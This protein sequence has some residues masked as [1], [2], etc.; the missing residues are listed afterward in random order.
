MADPMD[1]YPQLVA[2]PGYGN[3]APPVSASLSGNVAQS[4]GGA[5]AVGG[6][7]WAL[8]ALAVLFGLALHLLGD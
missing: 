4:F 7:P 2:G 6:E 5:A 3:P 8:V 1:Y